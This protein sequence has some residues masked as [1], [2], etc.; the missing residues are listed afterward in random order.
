MLQNS[1]PQVYEDNLVLYD[2]F[3]GLHKILSINRQNFANVFI[4]F[5]IDV[6]T[7]KHLKNAIINVFKKVID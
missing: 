5:F 1:T 3:S 7:Y 4:S 2:F 6:T